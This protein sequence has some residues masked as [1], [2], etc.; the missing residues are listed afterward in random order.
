[1]KTDATPQEFL[2]YLSN[3]DMAKVRAQCVEMLRNTDNAILGVAT[4]QYNNDSPPVA[5]IRLRLNV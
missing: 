4:E 5:I 2:E 3:P 1:M